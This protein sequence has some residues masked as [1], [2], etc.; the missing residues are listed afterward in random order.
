MF[1][2]FLKLWQKK[3]LT[4][5]ALA[6]STQ[7]LQMTSQMF[8]EAIWSLR[9]SPTGEMRIDIYQHDKII[10]KLERD[11]RKKVLVHLT[12]SEKSE[13][14][15][16]L[17]LVSVIIDIE[18]I[19]DYTKNITDLA[20]LHKDILRGGP[21]ESQLI[22]IEQ[23]VKNFFAWTLQAFP[24]SDAEIARQVVQN[25]K[26]VSHDSAE[27]TNALV[28]GEAELSLTDGVTLA[29][30][31]RFLKRV[32]AHLFNICTSIVNPFHRIG[33]REKTKDLS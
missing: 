17:T 6:M 3:S 15:A 28:K 12:I 14:I 20:I 30:Y 29:L 5:E 27:I 25:Y 8:D 7:M 24:V 11:I 33:F 31:S 23:R 26:S 2:E 9:E 4:A 1:S 19:G 16:G 22:S 10:N 21:F 18:R 13:I 32:A